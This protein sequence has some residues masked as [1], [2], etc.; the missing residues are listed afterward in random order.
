[1]SRQAELVWL[2][3]RRELLQA[4]QRLPDIALLLL[5]HQEPSESAHNALGLF[6][7][8]LSKIAEIAESLADQADQA[9]R[10]SAGENR[11]A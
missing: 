6:R 10:P 5:R 7:D 3:R 9:A 11:E 2:K 8:R 4:S 1:M